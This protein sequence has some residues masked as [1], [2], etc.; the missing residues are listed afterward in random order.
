VNLIL[1]E[2]AEIEHPIPRSDRRT[3]HV[4][5]VLRRQPGDTFD[6]GLVNGPHGKATLVRLD[7]AGMIV[8]FAWETSIPPA[9]PVTLVVGLPRPQTARDILRDATTLGVGGLHFIQTG[10]GDP[11]YLQS[12]LWSSGEWRRHVIAGA[13][14]AFTTR[15]PEVTHGLP[16]DTVLSGLASGG[17]HLALDNYEA[18]VALSDC[19]LP[20]GEPVVLAV[21]GER[22]W[23]DADRS[24]LRRHGFQLAHLGPRVLRTE[25]ACTVGLTLVRAALRLM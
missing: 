2:A 5:D 23:S 25:T 6:V 21:G 16:L 13:E 15:L 9:E 4:I 19:P 1:F 22:G 17:S 20:P 3:R 11:N 18:R 7:D 12:S 10:K 24:A 14:Q 8:S